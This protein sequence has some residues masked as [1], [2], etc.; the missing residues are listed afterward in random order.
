MGLWGILVSE[1]AEILDATGENTG[2]IEY[3][4]VKW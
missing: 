4:F 1:E 3:Y 2:Y